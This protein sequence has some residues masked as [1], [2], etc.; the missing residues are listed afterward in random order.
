MGKLAHGQQLKRTAMILMSV[1]VTT[2]VALLALAQ[3]KSDHT[4]VSVTA[5]TK[6][7][8]G[9]QPQIRAKMLMSVQ[10]P[11]FTYAAQTLTALILM[12]VTLVHAKLVSQKEL[13]L[14]QSK[15]VMMLM[16]ALTAPTNVAATQF[17]APH[18]AVMNATVWSAFNVVH[19]VQI[20]S[21]AQM[22]PNVQT[23]HLIFV[24][25]THSVLK[26]KAV[27]IAFVIRDT[28]EMVGLQLRKHAK[29]LMN[30]PLDLMFAVQILIALTQMAAT[31]VHAR[32]AT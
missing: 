5:A 12:A 2:S 24:G 30:V 32:L 21:H 6:K 28:N 26:S 15:S 14:M 16:N 22:L 1:L 19:S 13:G 20:S 7:M 17:A 31:H 18:M 8:Y 10:T 9:R 4:N 27:M 3:T 25:Q 11:T 23:Q 29:M